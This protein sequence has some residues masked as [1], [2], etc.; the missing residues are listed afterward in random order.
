[1]LFLVLANF[2]FKSS[3]RAVRSKHGPGEEFASSSILSCDIEAGKYGLTVYAALP[4]QQ[5]SAADKY[6]RRGVY[7]PPG[8]ARVVGAAWRGMETAQSSLRNELATSEMQSNGS[9]S[10]ASCPLERAPA[11]GQRARWRVFG[12]RSRGLRVLAASLQLRPA[13]TCFVTADKSL[14]SLTL[15]VVPGLKVRRGEQTL[16]K[17]HAPSFVWIEGAMNCW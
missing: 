4:Q 1:M 13:A 3:A 11:T 6:D 17:H 5:P 8:R 7:T 16:T 15:R 9:A 12:T 10:T 14:N 2:N